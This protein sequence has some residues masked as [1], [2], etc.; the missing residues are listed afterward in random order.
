MRAVRSPHH[1]ARIRSVDWSAAERMP[2]VVR[3]V[4]PDDVPRN[5]NT[6]LSLIGF[7]RD[8]E[9]LLSARKVAYRGEPIGAVIAETEAP[10]ARRRRRRAGRLGGAAPRPRRRG[11][12]EARRA[13]W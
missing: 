12:A 3:V 5:L 9:P 6:L 7:G 13:R 4:R 11:G 1:H 2:G 10:G 8:D